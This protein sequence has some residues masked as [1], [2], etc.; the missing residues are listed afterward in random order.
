MEEVHIAA[1]MFMNS[2]EAGR[3]W[4]TKAAARHV[5]ALFGN[6]PVVCAPFWSLVETQHPHR[7]NADPPARWKPK[8][9]IA[10]ALD[11]LMLIPN[12]K[13]EEEA[14]L[15]LGVLTRVRLK[16]KGDRGDKLTVVPVIN[17]R[18]NYN[19]K[20]AD[21]AALIA[22]EN[23]KHEWKLLFGDGQDAEHWRRTVLDDLQFHLERLAAEPSSAQST[24]IWR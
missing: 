8:V 22:F 9:R 12:T 4:A 24:K 7:S 6:N 21:P 10:A 13:E 3:R 16:L 2:P 5:M 11:A 15:V 14:K 17:L 23:F 20:H 1:F 19:A 18:K